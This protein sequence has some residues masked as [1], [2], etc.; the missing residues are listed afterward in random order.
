M[1]DLERHS[2]MIKAEA[3]RL[4]FDNCGI[5]PAVSLKEEAVRLDRW[6]SEGFHGTMKY[7]ENHVEKR[8]NITLLVPGTVSVITVLLNYF[9]DKKQKDPL[10]PVISKYA[11][12]KDYHPLI[13]KK[14]ASLLYYI[15]TDI[16]KTR[17]RGFT[18]S[19]PVMDKAWAV[20]AGTGW[21][22]KNTN[23]I[24]PRN[25]S[26]VF[27]GTL[28][29]DRPLHYDK[30]LP[31][32]CGSCTKCIEACPVK[33]IVK[34]YVVDGSRCI[35][36]FTVEH[37]GEIPDSCKGKFMN[38]VF[39]CDICQDVCPWNR[40]AKPHSTKELLPLP[41]L[42]EKNKEEWYRLSEEDFVAQFS[43]SPLKRAG[44]KGLMRNLRFLKEP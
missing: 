11:F 23:L 6:L 3:L 19:A 42:I 39:G 25:G 2:A 29:V 36:Y 40:K 44:Y 22:G 16:G 26:F 21:I 33:A 28:L 32:K 15:N 1:V 37:K 17:G 30:P 4:G 35:S 31:D 14:L 43:G 12:G 5:A 18:D 27:I 20:R 13:R 10:A 7:M 38:R 24:S 41:G 9:T 34:P 8:K